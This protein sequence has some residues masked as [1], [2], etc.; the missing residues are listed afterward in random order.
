MKNPRGNQ[1]SKLNSRILKA[2]EAFGNEADK[3]S[4][5]KNVG[6]P[7][8]LSPEDIRKQRTFTL[9]DNEMKSF[10]KIK[11]ILATQEVFD[12]NNSAILRTSLLALSKMPP[13][14]VVELF[15]LSK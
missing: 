2:T 6:R 9:S 5:N 7:K 4:L 3:G 11:A 12:A 15:K 14:Q 10:N 8:E 1:G 13:D